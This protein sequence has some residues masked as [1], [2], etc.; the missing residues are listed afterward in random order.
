MLLL[1]LRGLPT[2]D[3][4]FCRSPPR[5][6]PPGRQQYCAKHIV[7]SIAGEQPKRFDYFHRGIMAMI[8]RDAVIAE[9]GR[10]SS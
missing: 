3:S 8:G 7:A 5:Q 10:A 4:A 1:G 9:A 2:E 6:R